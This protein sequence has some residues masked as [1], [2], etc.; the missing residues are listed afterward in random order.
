[1]SITGKRCLTFVLPPPPRPLLS[2]SIAGRNLD[3]WVIR[4]SLCLRDWFVQKPFN[5]KT[6][7]SEKENKNKD[8]KQCTVFDILKITKIN[9]SEKN[10]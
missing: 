6:C 5:G 1:M 9:K 7:W 10:S 3:A 4:S 2:T 8:M